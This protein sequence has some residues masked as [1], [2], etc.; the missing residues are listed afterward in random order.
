MSTSSKEIKENANNS[1]YL[2]FEYPFNPYVR[3]LKERVLSDSFIGRLEKEMVH[4]TSYERFKEV[5]V[6]Y[7]KSVAM[8]YLGNKITFGKA[9]AIIDTYAAGFNALG[10]QE[11][12]VVSCSF[13]GCPDGI[14]SFYAL[15]KLGV[16]M[17][18]VNTATGL[19]EVKREL[20]NIP[21]KMFIG[22]DILLNGKSVKAIREAG[23]RTII[24]SSLCHFLPSLLNK[25]TLFY[26]MA[27]K[28][29]GLSKL[30]YNTY[31]VSTFQNLY[32][33]GKKN[34]EKVETVHYNPNHIAVYCY[35]SGTTNTPKACAQSWKGIDSYLHVMSL[36]EENR[37]KLED[38]VLSV[39]PLWISFSLYSMYHEPLCFGSQI[40]LD[41][42]FKPELF[43][44]RVEKYNFSIWM[45]MPTHAEAIARINNK[46][47]CSKIKEIITGGGPLTIQQKYACDNYIKANKGDIYTV[48]G[49][50]H[51]EL[52]GPIAYQ[53]NQNPT[54]GT[55]GVPLVGT[56]VKLIDPDIL[57]TLERNQEGYRVIDFT[58]VLEVSKDTAGLAIEYTPAQMEYYY[59]N[60]KD[61]K[62][63]FII[64]ENN[65]RWY[66]PGDILRRNEKDELSFVERK[67]RISLIM[68][69]NG[70]PAKISPA[71]VNTK[72]LSIP[73]IED[74]ETIL[75]EDAEIINK[76]ISLIKLV[77]GK[78]NDDRMIS[79]ILEYC[80][81][82]MAIYKIPRKFI[83]VDDL[84]KLTSGKHD[85]VSI[86]EICSK[87]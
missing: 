83:V 52:F 50:G 9:L 79:E 84:P 19:D 78:E 7:S 3:S 77:P 72:L 24:V 39:Y 21:S 36:T 70:L 58:K 45:T 22:N 87:S 6:R 76:P 55:C 64:D 17:H 66:I 51:T 4:K 85:L 25:D 42:L 49:I 35:T 30:I 82:E 54:A 28:K 59:G 10:L 81:L 13:L 26:W 48:Q 73:F 57:D 69:D 65:L 63:S 41:P 16:T 53:Y 68:D 14:F 5:A 71:E 12:D 75:L 44:R 46:C 86:K 37:F 34:K 23:N 38:I 2:Y 43:S 20:K 56:Q 29:K 1:G 15:D 80:K 18:M 40:A 67:D 62:D 60:E 11:D 74:C 47:D 27:E 8:N 31:N 32:M 33:I 61:S